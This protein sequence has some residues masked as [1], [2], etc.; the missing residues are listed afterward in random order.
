MPRDLITFTVGDDIPPPQTDFRITNHGTVWTFTPLT[1]RAEDW[2]ND[3]VENGV[4]LGHARAVDQ[5]MVE[6]N[7]TAISQAGL[8][9]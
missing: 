2:W 6:A 5:H 3:Y 4:A 1:I 9:A 7:L 8:S